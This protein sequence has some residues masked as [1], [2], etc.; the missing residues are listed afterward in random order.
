MI[1]NFAR[2]FVNASHCAGRVAVGV[3]AYAWGGYFQ[4]GSLSLDAEIHV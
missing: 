4:C 1:S 2:L 3:F